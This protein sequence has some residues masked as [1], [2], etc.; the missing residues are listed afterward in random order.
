MDKKR[1]RPPRRRA[2]RSPSPADRERSASGGTGGGGTSGGSGA[3]TTTGN[4]ASGDIDVTSGSGADG[5]GDAHGDREVGD[6]RD[7]AA[8]DRGDA[9]APQDPLAGAGDYVY[10]LLSAPG[11]FDPLPDGCDRKASAD[12]KYKVVYVGET[13]DFGGVVMR[14]GLGTFTDG[15]TVY[16]G[17]WRK[18]AMHGPDGRIE[19]ASGAVYVGGFV[20]G[21]YQGHGVYTWPSGAYY[22]GDFHN[23]RMHGIGV[24]VD[25]TGFAWHGEFYNNRG[26][27]LVQHFLDAD[28][29]DP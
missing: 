18:D 26:P 7:G 3:S 22:K 15:A 19:Y 25:A 6:G 23:N 21:M 10:P 12:G 16:K 5:Y 9:G 14:H 24:Y 27:G 28:A 4:G 8:G 1:N 17:H 2:P 11:A 20:D 13:Y 29:A